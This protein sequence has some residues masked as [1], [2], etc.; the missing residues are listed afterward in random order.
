MSSPRKLH[1]KAA[2]NVVNYLKKDPGRG[3]LFPSFG[4]MEVEGFC[5][6]D[7]ASRPKSRRSVTGYLVRL[8]SIPDIMYLY[9]KNSPLTAKNGEPLKIQSKP[10][11]TSNGRFHMFLLIQFHDTNTEKLRKATKLERVGSIDWT[12]DMINVHIP[13]P[14]QACNQVILPMNIGEA[15]QRQSCAWDW[16][17]Q[18][19]HLRVLDISENSFS[20]PIPSTLGNMSSL[21]ILDVS[22]NH[23]NG[24]LPESLGQL[25]NL[26]ELTVGDNHFS[27]KIPA[28]IFSLTELQSLNLSHNQFEG[29]IPNEIMNMKKLESLD[30]ASNQLSG[31]IPQDIAEL[32][33]LE[34]LN[35]SFNNFTGKIPTRTQLQGFDPQSFMGNPRL[36]GAP[37][38]K[39][40][41]DKE[42]H[43]EPVETNDSQ[44]D[45]FLFYFYVG[46]GVGFATGFWGVC[47]AIFFNKNFRHSYFR[48]LYRIQDKL[49][50]GVLKTNRFR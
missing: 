43:I 28:E 15:E 27:G 44:E 38:P 34:A 23:L 22:S 21:I 39:N 11:V 30:L 13:G 47:I 37:L 25:L 33:F 4:I 36:C 29:N 19:E 18:L 2:L 31:E 10:A 5:D 17:A 7:W 42:E 49:D 8:A 12:K 9:F 14:H 40:C 6:L 20:G 1:L 35:I 50:M 48:F 3:L 24:S 16:L 26:K 32:S 41:T 45:E 46:I